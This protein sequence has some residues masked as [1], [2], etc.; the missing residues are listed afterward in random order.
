[1]QQ[2]HKKFYNSE[3]E[4]RPLSVRLRLCSNVLLSLPT[5]RSKSFYKINNLITVKNTIAIQTNLMGLTRDSTSLAV[6]FHNEQEN[7]VI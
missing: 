3:V 1:M 5:E 2:W 7:I 6:L 4:W